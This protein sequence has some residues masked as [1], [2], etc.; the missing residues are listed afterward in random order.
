MTDAQAAVLSG[1][2]FSRRVF[3]VTDREAVQVTGVGPRAGVGGPVAYLA[4]H[5]VPEVRFVEL[6][7]AD[8]REFQY[9]EPVFAGYK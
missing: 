9:L 5:G 6:R 7:A 1:V 2:C 8:P 4:G 3:W